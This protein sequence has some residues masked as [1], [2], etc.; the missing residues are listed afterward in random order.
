MAEAVSMTR[1]M[2]RIALALLVGLS[3]VPASAQS[4]DPGSPPGPGVASPPEEAPEADADEAQDPAIARDLRL[5]DLEEQVSSLKEQVHR[6][7]TRLTLLREQVLH[8]AIAEAQAVLIHRNDLSAQLSLLQVVY[9]LDGE[10]IYFRDSAD[11]GLDEQRSFE[12]FRGSVLPGNH[13]LS[14]ELVLR[15]EGGVFT[16]VEG[17][18]FRIK[19]SYTFYAA[20]GRITK[21]D[22]VAHERGGVSADLRDKPYVRFDVQQFQYTKDNLERL[23]EGQ[24]VEPLDTGE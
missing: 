1:S 14:V 13:I 15:G 19:S 4:A 5:R 9:Y 10:Q 23:A 17:Y 3:A 7:K 22:A 2:T 11:G 18:E 24:P 8:N 21:V 20:K 16:Y 12:V 6:S